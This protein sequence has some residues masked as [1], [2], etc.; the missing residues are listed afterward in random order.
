MTLK[1][2][3]TMRVRNP[4]RRGL[5]E[6]EDKSFDR[7]NELISVLKLLCGHSSWCNIGT[8]HSKR[9]MVDFT[10]TAATER[11][12]TITGEG[13]QTEDRL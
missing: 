11:R 10:N 6:L 4:F 13:F 7:I 12:R 9:L 3:F 8:R 5:S 2:P 1:R